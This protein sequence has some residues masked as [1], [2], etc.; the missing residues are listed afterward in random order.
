MADYGVAGVTVVKALKAL[1]DEGL[2]EARL[3]WGMFVRRPKAK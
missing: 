1:A 3:G 2:I